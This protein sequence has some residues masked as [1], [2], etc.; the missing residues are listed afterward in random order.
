MKNIDNL[1]WQW[2]VLANSYTNHLNWAWSPCS[3]ATPPLTPPSPYLTSVHLKAH[4]DSTGFHLTV[5]YIWT[6]DNVFK[7]GWTLHPTTAAWK[8]KKS[9]SFRSERISLFLPV[10]SSHRSVSKHVARVCL[11]D[12]ELLHSTGQGHSCDSAFSLFV[13]MYSRNKRLFFPFFI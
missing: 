8:E 5:H 6:F 3:T 7:S 2:S 10:V 1:S 4:A 9:K 13:L 12:V 11:W